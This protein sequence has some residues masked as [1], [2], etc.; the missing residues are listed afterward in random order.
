[1][2]SFLHN[3]RANDPSLTT[4]TVTAAVSPQSLA[5]ALCHNTVVSQLVLSGCYHL[6]LSDLC[7]ILEALSDNNSLRVLDVSNMGLTDEML[8]HVIDFVQ[9][10]TSLGRLDVSRNELSREIAV[11]LGLSLRGHLSVRTLV[12]D[13]CELGDDGGAALMVALGDACPLHKLNLAHNNMGD[14][15]GQSLVQM[16]RKCPNIVQMNLNGNFF[17]RAC[18][19]SIDIVLNSNLHRFGFDPSSRPVSKATT[20][21]LSLTAPA[22]ERFVPSADAKT[23]FSAL[24]RL[25]RGD[26]AAQSFP[27]LSFLLAMDP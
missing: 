12:A 22:A 13:H 2:A 7:S 19:E 21:D 24:D 9:Q 18:I 5:H 26:I 8:F 10:S 25:V 3:V 4:L 14:V 15:S 23:T 6:N 1:M 20:R 27:S 11:A 17:P 16:V